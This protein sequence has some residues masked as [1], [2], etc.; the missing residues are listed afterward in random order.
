[1]RVNGRLIEIGLG[2]FRV[3]PK[4][5]GGDWL[6]V[7]A[8]ALKREGFTFVVSLLTEPENEE[9][10]LT[11][12]ELVCKRNEIEFYSFP[13]ID[14][15]TPRNR[16][17]FENLVERL[18]AKIEKGE[19]GHFHCRAGLG[20]AP[21]LACAIMQKAGTNSDEAWRMLAESRGQPV[22]DTEAQRAWVK[23]NSHSSFTDLDDAFSKLLENGL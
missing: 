19:R 1:M 15:S 7:D 5:R 18:L 4:P 10:G 23:K 11:E 3:S 17:D 16:E 21:L 22:P 20:R 9:L 2:H 14:R 13:I 8:Q 6:E 12:E